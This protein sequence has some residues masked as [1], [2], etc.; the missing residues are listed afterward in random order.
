MPV[1]LKIAIGGFAG[2]LLAAVVF[3]SCS[4]ESNSRGLK[5][6]H[7]ELLQSRHEPDMP[8]PAS[9]SHEA[10]RAGNERHAFDDFSNLL[11][12]L[13]EGADVIAIMHAA[14][15]SLALPS[16]SSEMMEKGDLK[17]ALNKPPESLIN[18]VRDPASKWNDDPEL[19]R[20]VIGRI[21]LM[22]ALFG[23]NTS[24]VSQ[25]PDLIF[26]ASER[27]VPTQEDLLTIRIVRQASLVMDARP[28]LVEDDT[29]S[30]IRLASSSNA[31]C[32][33]IALIA[34]DALQTT[35]EQQLAFYQCYIGEV[36]S[37]VARLFVECLANSDLVDAENL[38]EEFKKLSPAS[39]EV[40]D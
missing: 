27:V 37:E 21:S 35:P 2:C 19:K 22:T 39:P 5:S 15:I 12:S 20:S 6:E 17:R 30:W 7:Q 11:G 8:H 10:Q 1:K 33:A 14:W 18:E 9:Q 32:R 34:F 23:A 28:P 31:A 3:V 40:I 16:L 25:F 29:S 36:D 26:E 13:H 38:V 24:A 4:D